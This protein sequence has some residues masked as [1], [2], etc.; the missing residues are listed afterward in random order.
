MRLI[1]L[2]LA[3]MLLAACNQ[4]YTRAPLVSE[5]H[6]GG[7]PEFRPGLWSISGY[8]QNCPFDVRKPLRDWPECAVSLE[9]RRGQMFLVSGHQRYLAQTQ[10]LVGET[11]AGSEPILVQAHWQA[12][13]LADPRAP[14]P[15]DTD[16]PFYGWT[17]YA[18]TPTRLD[19]G[20]LIREAS[21]VQALCGPPDKTFTPNAQRLDSK[22]IDARFRGYAS[23]PFA[24]L[25]MAGPSC[26][27]KDLETVKRALT[28]SASLGEPRTLKWVRDDP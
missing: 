19:P 1:P 16:N 22:G 4:V 20:G 23:R 26:T 11:T 15:K 2:L 7:D 21:V 13:I 12:D 3:T 17:Y 8:D 14:E 10:R 24:G 9:F 6:E 28:L 5:R 25:T 18:V 27:A